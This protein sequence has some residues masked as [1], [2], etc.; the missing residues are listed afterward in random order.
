MTTLSPRCCSVK[1]TVLNHQTGVL[2]DD[3]AGFCGALSGGVMDHTDLQPQRSGADGNGFCCDGR[4][5]FGV[6]KT[7]HHVDVDML[8]GLGE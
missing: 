6:A 3:Q 8:R 4:N 2:H 5:V 7:V 1:L